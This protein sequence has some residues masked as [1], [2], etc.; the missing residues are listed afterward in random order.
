MAGQLNEVDMEHMVGV[1]EQRQAL[2]AKSPRKARPA[3]LARTTRIEAEAGHMA[4]GA[5]CRRAGLRTHLGRK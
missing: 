3:T 2:P 1:E 5:R 4:S